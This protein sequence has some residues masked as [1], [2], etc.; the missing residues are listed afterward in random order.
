[1]MEVQPYSIVLYKV[2]GS[3]MVAC[4]YLVQDC[5]QIQIEAIVT[6]FIIFGT[7]MNILYIIKANISRMITLAPPSHHVDLRT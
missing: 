7:H 3:Y 2:D 5:Y 6:F 4:D 1:M